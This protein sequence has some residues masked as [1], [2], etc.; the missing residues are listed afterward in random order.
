L[1]IFAGEYKCG[2]RIQYLQDSEGFTDRD[3][4]SRVAGLEFPGKYS[5]R[6]QNA[7]TVQIH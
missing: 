5:S 2:D 4:C 3:A 6:K 1:N 7:N